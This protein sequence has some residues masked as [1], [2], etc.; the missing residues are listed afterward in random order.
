MPNYYIYED[1][2]I[3]VIYYSI[4]IYLYLIIIIILLNST[5][6]INHIYNND[7]SFINYFFRCILATCIANI[8]SQYLFIL[9]NSKRVYIK[10]INKMKN[11]LYGKNRILKY[12]K[13]DLID[14]IN[15]NLYFKLLFLF[16]L[17]IIIFMITFYLSFCF[18][19]AYYNTQFLVIKCLI[20][21]ILIS[22]ISPFFLALIPAKLRK[23]AIENNDNKLYILS[24]LVDSYFLP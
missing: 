13:K 22:Q 23:K 19:I 6:V 12:V 10:Y 18:W 1:Q 5:S 24:K 21:C 7:F 14:L 20:I 3:T 11:S 16:C 9:T 15:N 17:N 2:R 4:K 8:I